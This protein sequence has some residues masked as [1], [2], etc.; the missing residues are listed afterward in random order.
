MSTTRFSFRSKR[1][2]ELWHG[3]LPPCPFRRSANGKVGSRT[4][5]R[6]R[7]G[8]VRF[9]AAAQCPLLARSNLKI[10]RAVPTRFEFEEKRPIA[11]GD[12]IGLIF[13]VAG[14]LR[15]HKIR[16]EGKPSEEGACRS[17]R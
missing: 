16:A 12:G 7:V 9:R 13:D 3:G 2:C 1:T 15:L 14:G 17:H 6:L 10:S 4:A 11:L 5:V 8:N